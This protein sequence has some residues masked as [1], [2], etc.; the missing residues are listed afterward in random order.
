MR[1]KAS[2][3][4]LDAPVTI[5]A[6]SAMARY[7]ITRPARSDLRLHRVPPAMTGSPSRRLLM[8]ALAAA[9][10]LGGCGGSGG[11]G[12]SSTSAGNNGAQA[13]PKAGAGTLEQLKHSMPTG[14]SLALSGEA[15]QA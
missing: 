8:P 7:P 9:L 15:Y 14:P 11:G 12:S 3:I 6:R 4:P 2:P 13:W 5:A 10:A 1:A